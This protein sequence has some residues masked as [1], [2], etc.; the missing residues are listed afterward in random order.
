MRLGLYEARLKKNS[1]IK[2]FINQNRFKKDT[3]TDMK[4]IL[5]TRSV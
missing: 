3:D 1:L 2:K 4:L 5:A